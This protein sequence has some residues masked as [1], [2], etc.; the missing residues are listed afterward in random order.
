VSSRVADI[1][2]RKTINEFQLLLQKFGLKLQNEKTLLLA[3]VENSHSK[4]S[5]CF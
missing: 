4:I 3:F 5:W 1:R 2:Y